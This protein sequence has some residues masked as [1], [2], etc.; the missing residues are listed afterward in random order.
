MVNN[1]CWNVGE[2]AIDISSLKWN[3]VIKIES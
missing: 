3:K 1:L 2:G